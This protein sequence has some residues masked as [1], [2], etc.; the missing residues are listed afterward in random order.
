MLEA[1]SPQLLVYIRV[2]SHNV[3]QGARGPGREQEV[4]GGE[5]MGST[6]ESRGSVGGGPIAVTGKF[7][8]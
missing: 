2:I 6:G 5:I 4:R 3:T 7:S 1:I 8:E